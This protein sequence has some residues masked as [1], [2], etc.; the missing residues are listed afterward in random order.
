MTL[1]RDLCLCAL[2]CAS[3]EEGCGR[4]DGS[5][6]CTLANLF[7]VVKSNL[8]GKVNVRSLSTLSSSLMSS[9]AMARVKNPCTQ[10]QKS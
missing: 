4:H 7:L 5:L 2:L 1:E 9:K 6:M 8:A 10:C 3:I